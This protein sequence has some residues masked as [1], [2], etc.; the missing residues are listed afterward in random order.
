MY[1]L[2]M[3]GRYPEASLF[4][5][6]VVTQLSGAWSDTSTETEFTV[7]DE[8]CPVMVLKTCAK[9]ISV[10]K[11]SDYKLKKVKLRVHQTKQKYLLGLP[12]PISRKRRVSSDIH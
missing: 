3:K 4:V 11:S 10:Y 2:E 9:R 1:R 8:A 5:I 6:D 12:L 7:G